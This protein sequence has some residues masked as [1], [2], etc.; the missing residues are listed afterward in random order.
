MRRSRRC[1]RSSMT[2]NLPSAHPYCSPPGVAEPKRYSRTV[3]WCSLSYVRICGSES[4][5]WQLAVC[6]VIWVN[7]EPKSA[8]M[9]GNRRETWESSTKYVETWLWKR[10]AALVICKF[11]SLMI[12][13]FPRYLS[14]GLNAHAR[15]RTDPD[16]F[17]VWAGAGKAYLARG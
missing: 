7:V 16:R 4:I 15:C 5:G 9:L 14:D 6:L 1:S 10:F 8:R 13:K 3:C 12:G 2:P 11:T 17:L